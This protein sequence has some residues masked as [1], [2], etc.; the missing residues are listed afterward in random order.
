MVI[1]KASYNFVLQNYL[2]VH[3][4][5][6][7]NL[8]LIMKK[9]L[10][11]VNLTIPF[12]WF[13]PLLPSQYCTI[14]PYITCNSSSTSSFSIYCW[15]IRWRLKNFRARA[16][17]TFNFETIISKCWKNSNFNLKWIY[18]FLVLEKLKILDNFYSCTC[19]HQMF[20]SDTDHPTPLAQF[21]GMMYLLS[22]LTVESILI[23]I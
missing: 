5:C 20:P 8:T 11:K 3:Q 6:S 18:W 9:S 7:T 4:L 21:L 23:F 10:F 22:L 17:F 12:A 2:V 13:L 1:P 19:T 15:S 16:C 14:M